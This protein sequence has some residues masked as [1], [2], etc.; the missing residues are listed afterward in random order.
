[1]QIDYTSPRTPVYYANKNAWLSNKYRVIANQ[2][3]TRSSKTFS[4]V[5]LLA[6]YIAPK[7][8]KEITIVSSSLPHL[9]RGALKDFLQVM[10]DAGIYDENCFNKTDHIYTYSNGSY[11]EFFGCEDAGKVR[12][13]SRDILF[14]NEANLLGNPVYKQLALRTRETIFI[15]FNPVEETSWVYDVADKTSNLLIHSTYQNNRAF[16]TQEQIAE[17]EA[18]KD[19]DPNLWKVFGLGLRGASED[20]IYTHH[21]YC[22][23]LPLKG[24]VFMGQDFGYN[25]PS[26]LVL[27]ELYEGAV[28]VKELLYERKLTTSDLIERY[29]EIGVSKTIEIFCDN[30]EPKTIEELFRAGYNVKEA[31]KDVTEGIRKVKSLPLYICENSSNIVKEIKGYRWRTDKDGKKIKEKDRDEPVKFNDHAM[32]AIRYAV[33]TKLSVPTYSWVAM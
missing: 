33:F 17:I 7:F 30:A 24:E 14:V 10:E 5:Q 20:L 13:P 21:K 2:G 19:G 1:M 16:L 4:I 28:Y 26:A 15:D 27:C 3:S 9:K 11:I 6:L 18:L 22:A 29:K 32:D 8:K 23:D 25:V 12:G 31:D